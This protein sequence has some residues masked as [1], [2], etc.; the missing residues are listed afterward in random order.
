MTP[1]R[2]NDLVSGNDG[3]TLQSSGAP[4]SGQAGTTT[5]PGSTFRIMVRA[6][7]NDGR[8]AASEAVILVDNDINSTVPYHVLLWHD[9]VD[10]AS[11][12]SRADRGGR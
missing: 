6:A 4:P 12:L 2:L 1:E 5:D 10:L 8:K 3:T 9:D 7:F 11:D